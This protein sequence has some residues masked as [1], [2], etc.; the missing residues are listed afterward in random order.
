MPGG[1]QR[2]EEN[3]AGLEDG[4]CWGAT[5]DRTVREGR[6]AKPGRTQ[7][8]RT[9]GASTAG[10]GHSGWNEQADRGLGG[11]AGVLPPRGLVRAAV[12]PDSGSAMVLLHADLA[13]HGSKLI[14][15]LLWQTW[16]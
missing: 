4:A 9:S 7:R 3:I 14:F 15:P 12:A 11:R 16:L 5:L 13:G 6:R 1:G 2:S 10:R 8:P